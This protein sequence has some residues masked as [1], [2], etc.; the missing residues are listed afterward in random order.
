MKKIFSFLLVL[1]ALVS[2][3]I[4]A[5]NANRMIV[6]NK[7][8]SKTGYVIEDIDSIFFA[9]VQGT[10]SL[11]LSIGNVITDNPLSP[12][13]KASIKKE[14]MCRSF[15][16]AVV[17]KYK[18]DAMFDDADV[19]KYF[20]SFVSDYYTEDLNDQVLKNVR[21]SAG[22]VNTVLAVAYDE[23][24]VA[25]AV[26]R[27]DFEVAGDF[28]VQITDVKNI[29]I[30]LDITPSDENMFYFVRCEEQKK[31][32]NMSDEALFNADKAYFKK[33]AEDYMSSIEDVVSWNAQMG[34]QTDFE[35]S[36]YKHS[37]SFLL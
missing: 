7:D 16:Y 23:Y 21:V 2:S 22:T 36:G 34:S 14:G 27:A 8:G 35:L 15:R 32:D 3:G 28:D 26:S 4:T 37:R 30:T 6:V 19:M 24:D 10:A 11:N 12:M 17:P 29:A 9:K 18:S 1:F 13:V 25:C 33:M 20:N 5:Q 31:V